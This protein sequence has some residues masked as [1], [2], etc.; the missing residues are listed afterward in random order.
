MF[1]ERNEAGGYRHKLFRR[2]I[3]VIDMRGLDID[4]IALAAAYD[5][6]G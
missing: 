3:H 1:Q 2:N 6:I 4:K 5:T